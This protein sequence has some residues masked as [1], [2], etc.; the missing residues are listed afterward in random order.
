MVKTEPQTPLKRIPT[1][2]PQVIG[3]LT[4]G[5]IRRLGYRGGIKLF[6]SYIYEEI[7]QVASD[8]FAKVVP[9]A[10]VYTEHAGQ[11]TVSANHMKRSLK[12]NGCQ[13]YC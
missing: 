8:F 6:P 2:Q 1:P 5:A 11:K 13:I 10:V 4:K 7:N 12:T 3:F 9:D